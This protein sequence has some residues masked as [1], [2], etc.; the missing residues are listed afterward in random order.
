MSDQMEKVEEV[1]D[2][3]R[4]V[5]DAKLDALRTEGWG[6][7]ALADDLPQGWP[8][9]WDGWDTIDADDD[10]RD[11]GFVVDAEVVAGIVARLTPKQRAAAGAVVEF[12]G[13]S[14]TGMFVTR[15]VIRPDGAAADVAG[16]GEDDD[17]G[18]PE[19]GA[20]D[21]CPDCA[22]VES[23]DCETCGGQGVVDSDDDDWQDGDGNT[24]E[25]EHVP[26]P[27]AANGPFSISAA[28]AQEVTIARTLA[29]AEAVGRADPMLAL[30]LLVASLDAEVWARRV[31]AGFTTFRG[32]QPQDTGMN[33]GQHTGP[34]KTKAGFDA[35]L[36]AAMAFT[37]DEV[38]CK[39]RTHIARALDVSDGRGGALHSAD[40]AVMAVV[41]PGTYLDAARRQFDPLNYF[42]RATKAV[43]LAAIE[44]MIEAG[45]AAHFAPVDVLADMKKAE[46]GKA[47]AEAASACGWLPPEMRVA[48]YAIGGTAGNAMGQGTRS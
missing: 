24:G 22:G 39:L 31:K 38:L 14:P 32:H 4:E 10:G 11:D 41:P 16:D 5:A 7:V 43:A 26:P 12:D 33:T 36:V 23:D 27:P 40:A 30:R 47:A 48:G 25:S 45:Q 44:E 1:A 2:A 3:K 17:D 13:N 46:I 18:A 8:G 28:L 34:R 21:I 35:A 20:T 9:G 15:G 19:D 29:A 42:H 6:W 37:D